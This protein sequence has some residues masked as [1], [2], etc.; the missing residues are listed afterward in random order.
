[1]PVLGGVSENEIAFLQKARGASA[2]TQLAWSWLSEFIIR[3]HLAG[4]LG[5]VGPPIV[6]RCFQFLSD[7]M[8]F[9]N[10]AR[11]TM[12]IPFPFPHAQLTAIFTSVLVVV[13]PILMSEYTTLPW[14]GARLVSHLTA[15]ASLAQVHR[16]TLRS[17]G[18][19]V[20]VKIQYPGLEVLSY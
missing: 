17:S 6:S 1:M 3:E 8:I 5:N 9:Y 19:T 2:K 15:A 7:G 11:K 18:H 14:L 4:S 10:H 12:F 20:A 16:A 13:V